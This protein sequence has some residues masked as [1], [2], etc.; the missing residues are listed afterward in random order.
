MTSATFSWTRLPTKQH[1]LIP[2]AVGDL[3]WDFS[4]IFYIYIFWTIAT[5]QPPST[6]KPTNSHASYAR[7]LWC[8]DSSSRLG[9]KCDGLTK[10]RALAVSSLVQRFVGWVFLLG[11]ILICWPSVSSVLFF[12]VGWAGG[13]FSWSIV[14]FRAGGSTVK[15]GPWHVLQ[16][17][18]MGWPI[19]LLWVLRQS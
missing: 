11:D 2:A 8:S 7:F 4:W 17:F 15:I 5:S 14:C 9:G 10:G 6:P 1:S 12:V 13:W 18:W 16:M 3:L 19:A